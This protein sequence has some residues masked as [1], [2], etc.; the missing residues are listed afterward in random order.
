MPAC[1]RSSSRTAR[2]SSASASIRTRRRDRASTSRSR[3]SRG[4]AATI[5]LM[6]NQ[7]QLEAD[8]K[9]K[10][11]VFVKGPFC[12]ELPHRGRHEGDAGLLRA[13]RH[14]RRRSRAY[15][16]DSVRSQVPKMD[17]DHVFE[18]KDDISNAIQEHVGPAMGQYG[19]AIVSCL[20]IDII[21]G[22]AGGGRD[23]RHPGASAPAG[24]R[25]LE[26]RG[27]EDFGHQACRGR[28]RGRLEASAGRG[29]RQ[30]AQGDH[31]GVSGLGRGVPEARRRR[32]G[33]RRL[34][35]C[36]C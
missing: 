22:G 24:G 15:A 11:N 29:H 21:A 1:S 5:N 10:D 8:T 35:R 19:I 7:V 17:L 28:G 12:G 9:T 31:G 25:R 30:P 4:V 18:L 3:S 33:G 2:S 20:V 14:A 36:C 16:L 32:A 23:E 34:C 27:G 13:R 6:V 26:G